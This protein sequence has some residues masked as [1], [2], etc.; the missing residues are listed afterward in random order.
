MYNSQDI[1]ERI[2]DLA[3]QKD[4]PIRT[5]L[6]DLGKEENMLQHMKS[7]MPKADTLGEIADY[8]NCSVDYLLG[9]E[10]ANLSEDEMNRLKSEFDMYLSD[11]QKNLVKLKDIFS[12]KADEFEKQYFIHL[13]EKNRE[14]AESYIKAL[15]DTQD[16]T[17]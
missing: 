8:L 16:T 3:N 17:R 7:S 14:L 13:S 4:I 2:K 1:A 12:A 10:S 9:R 15:I 11:L 5:M 6:R